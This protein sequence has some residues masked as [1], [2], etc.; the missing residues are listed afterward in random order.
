MKTLLLSFTL[1]AGLWAQTPQGLPKVPTVDAGALARETTHARETSTRRWNH[2]WRISEGVLIAGTAADIASSLHF[3]H[4]GQLEG[5]S[6]LAPSGKYGARAVGIEAGAV[7]GLLVV[8]E[9][10]AR[11]SPTA[12]KVF[13]V[14]NFGYGAVQAVNVHHNLVGY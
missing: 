1:G 7:G 2:A 14:V 10:L 6:F 8:Q 3:S 13:S 4:A 11:R 5:N 12:K 9:F